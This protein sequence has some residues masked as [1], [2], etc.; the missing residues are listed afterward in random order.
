MKPQDSLYPPDW[1]RVAERDWERIQKR[2][3]EEDQEDAGFHLQQAL[4]KYL[5]AFLLANGWELE[6]THEVSTLLEEAIKYKAELEAFSQLCHRVENYY[7][8]ERYPLTLDAGISSDEVTKDFEEAKKLRDI[9][10]ATFAQKPES[11]AVEQQET[12]R[13]KAQPASPTGLDETP[14]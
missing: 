4:E 14:S 1:L 6:K 9:I 10:L 2:L 12:S 5:K 3:G 13:T 7:F 11:P 8:I